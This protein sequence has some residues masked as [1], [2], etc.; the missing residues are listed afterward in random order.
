MGGAFLGLASRDF[1]L[2]H[3][4]A[5][6]LMG[7]IAEILRKEHRAC[8]RCG[9]GPTHVYDPIDLD[10]EIPEGIPVCNACLRDRLAKDMTAFAGKG[11]L[12]EP[13]LG[14]D[15]L[16]FKRLGDATWPELVITAARDALASAGE[17]CDDCSEK[18]RFVWV[19]SP[20]DANLWNEDWLV[21][22]TEGALKVSATL[23]AGCAASRL[24]RSIENRGLYFEAI[25][26][27]S[28][29]EDGV[30]LGSSL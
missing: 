6:P 1:H 28:G 10:A 20:R 29:S 30:M 13:A 5:A 18:G 2:G 21:S 4:E 27:P 7:W 19:V 25:V 14:P 12:F 11:L 15:A 26:P 3:F 24:A 16:M 9:L 8:E 17:N 23:C 22:L